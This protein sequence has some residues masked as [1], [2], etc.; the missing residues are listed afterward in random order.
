MVRASLRMSQRSSLKTTIVSSL[1]K[2]VG[3]CN[4]VFYGFAW[5]IVFNATSQYFNYIV[6]VSFIGGGNGVPMNGQMKWMFQ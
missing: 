6:A 5:F 1:F 2:W 3:S 4:G